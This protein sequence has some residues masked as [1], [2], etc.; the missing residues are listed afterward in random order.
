[1]G[2]NDERMKNLRKKELTEKNQKNRIKNNSRSIINRKKW[3]LVENKS[4]NPNNIMINSE[5]NNYKINNSGNNNN[6]NLNTNNN[7]NTNN[8]SYGKEVIIPNASRSKSKKKHESKKTMAAHIDYK[9]ISKLILNNNTNSIAN[10]NFNHKSNHNYEL[11]SQ[12]N[13]KNINFLNFYNNNS[14]TKNII[15]KDSITNLEELLNDIHTVNRNITNLNKFNLNSES[16]INKRRKNWGEPKFN[17]AY[18]DLSTSIEQGLGAAGNVSSKNKKRNITNYSNNVISNHNLNSSF[19]K[20]S[21]NDID[22][23]NSILGGEYSNLNSSVAGVSKEREIYLGMNKLSNSSNYNTNNNQNLINIINE[24]NSGKNNNNRSPNMNYNNNINNNTEYMNNSNNSINNLQINHNDNN[25]IKGNVSGNIIQFKN[26]GSSLIYSNL[27]QSSNNQLNYDKNTYSSNSNNNINSNPDILIT[28]SKS[29][30]KNSNLRNVNNLNKLSSYKQIFKEN[31]NEGGNSI[32]LTNRFW[33]GTGSSTKRK[34]FNLNNSNEG[35]KKDEVMLVLE[36]LNNSEIL[37]LSNS[38]INNRIQ[39]NYIDNCQISLADNNN[40]VNINL[41]S[42]N[43]V[44]INKINYNKK[45]NNLTTNLNGLNNNNSSNLNTR[46]FISLNSQKF[47]KLEDLNNSTNKNKNFLCANNSNLNL[48]SNK[49]NQNINNDNSLINNNYQLKSNCNNINNL[50]SNN[51]TTERPFSSVVNLSKLKADKLKMI[52][53]GSVSG[54]SPK[55]NIPSIQFIYKSPQNINLKSSQRPLS[56]I[57]K[58]K[59]ILNSKTSTNYL[60]NNILFNNNI[61]ANA[62][63]Q[64]LSNPFENSQNAFNLKSSN[65]YTTMDRFSSREKQ[66]N[67]FNNFNNN[68]INHKISNEYDNAIFLDD[69]NLNTL[70]TKDISNSQFNFSRKKNQYPNISNVEKFN[71]NVVSNNNNYNSNNIFSNLKNLRDPSTNSKNKNINENINKIINS[72]VVQSIGNNQEVNQKNNNKK[73]ENLKNNSLNLNIEFNSNQNYNMNKFNNKNKEINNSKTYSA[74]KQ[75]IIENK[76]DLLQHLEKL[77]DKKIKKALKYIEKLS[78]NNFDTSELSVLESRTFL[79]NPGKKIDKFNINYIKTDSINFGNININLNNN[80]NS[81][82]SVIHQMNSTLN[83]TCG[84]P[85][86]KKDFSNNSTLIKSKLMNMNNSIN[87]GNIIKTNFNDITKSQKP[88]FSASMKESN[89]KYQTL[90]DEVIY[91]SNDKEEVNSNTNET[92]KTLSA[93]KSI[94]FHLIIKNHFYLL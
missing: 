92:K 55:T 20:I 45:F 13:N 35:I 34:N 70:I 91:A 87:T 63:N 4:N 37:N 6:K 54:I 46:K 73:S 80:L 16:P 21:E 52:D 31:P 59:S 69:H 26:S 90:E 40:N 36:N 42:D 11:N 38:G 67:I 39:T 22:G 30:S 2:A 5:N 60:N 23:Y 64:I 51:N 8:Y 82:N 9:A 85:N 19:N 32:M 25:C 86:I 41:N 66:T 68:D 56:H 15:S 75:N 74:N 81:T 72:N 50:S 61:N 28:A 65:T 94:K 24:K 71:A 84:T 3:D 89:K 27:N 14:S 53:V 18:P 78:E 1:M 7:S 79:E 47:K 62:Y 77:D 17:I 29:N 93:I 58:S 12:N 76:T 44:K 88:S 49:N 10:I 48:Y 83:K 33:E 43:G 57:Q